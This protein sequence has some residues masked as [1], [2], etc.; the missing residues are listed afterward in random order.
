M[1]LQ[2]ADLF[3]MGSYKE[4]WS[5]S[6]IEAVATGLPAC[7]TDFSSADSI[8]LEGKNGYVVK[9]HNID[10]FVTKMQDTGK[11]SRPVYFEHLLNYSVEKLQS[12]LLKV[13]KLL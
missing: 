1:Y 7:V 3:I 13:W 5:T 8:I 6:L 4:G 10:E 12:E 2:A 11:L 9:D